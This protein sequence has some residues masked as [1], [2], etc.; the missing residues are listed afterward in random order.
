M[1]PLRGSV[2]SWPSI[3]PAFRRFLL[4][5][6]YPNLR[7]KVGFMKFLVGKHPIAPARWHNLF[8]GYVQPKTLP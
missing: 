5:H 6:H 8:S 3:A 2:F 1:F 7:V 4:F